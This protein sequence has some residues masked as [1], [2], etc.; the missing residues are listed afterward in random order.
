M[1]EISK[2]I[3]N[4]YVIRKTDQQKLSFIKL[5][6]ENYKCEIQYNKGI[7]KNRNIIIG[8]IETA[9]VV[10]TAHYDTP[11]RLII[12]NIVS[13]KSLLRTIIIQVILAL[14]LVI[15]TL[16]IGRFAQNVIFTLINL[17]NIDLPFIATYLLVLISNYG[18]IVTLLILM[19]IGPAN[20]TNLNDNTSGVVTLLEL[21]DKLTEEQRKECAFVFFD[22]EEKGLIGSSYFNKKY[23]KLM[24]DRFLV[25]FDCVGDGDFVFI[26]YNKN[27][28]DKK[29]TI[30]NC[31]SENEKKVLLNS[32]GF[33][34]YSSDQI[35]FKNAI[36]VATLKYNKT[37]GYYLDKI[38]TSKDTNLDE[39]NIEYIVESFVKYQEN[40]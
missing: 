28:K 40:L 7:F 36:G 2:K 32:N 26:H 17:A 39:K 24:K 37:L 3:I 12:P 19:F 14:V 27:A 5:I 6:D 13:P 22:N 33:S 15:P 1:L 20:K 18:L 11:A 30:T 4:D 29:E 38:H 25:N 16:L 21:Y 10:Y 8:D 34:Q 9:K 23:K 35:W 31:F